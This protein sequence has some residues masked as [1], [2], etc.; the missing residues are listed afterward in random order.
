MKTGMVNTAECL[1]DG[2]S[3][4]EITVVPLRNDAVS[5]QINSYE[6]L[7]ELEVSISP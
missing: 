2:K 4:K 3:V 1:P 6:W 7:H 5:H